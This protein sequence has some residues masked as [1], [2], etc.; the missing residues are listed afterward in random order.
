MARKKKIVDLDRD[1]GVAPGLVAKTKKRLVI[2]GGRSHPALT[3]AVAEALGTEIAPTEHRTFASGEILTRRERAMLGGDQAR[4]ELGGDVA[5]QFRMG[6]ARRDD[7][8]L[9]RLHDE[10]GSDVVPLSVSRLVLA[11]HRPLS[12]RTGTWPRLPPRPCPVGSSRPTPR[13]CAE[14]RRSWPAHRRGHPC[15]RRRLRRSSHLL[16]A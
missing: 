9:L 1:N 16:P 12:V 2:A 14:G 3:A 6:A 7:Q 5:G 10:T 13:R 8:P 15:G 11:R 4:S